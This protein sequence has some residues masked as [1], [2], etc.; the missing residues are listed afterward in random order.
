M[1]AQTDPQ[2]QTTEFVRLGAGATTPGARQVA[3]VPGAEVP[4]LTLELPERLRGQAREQVAR[5]QLRDRIVLDPAQVEMRPFHAQ[6]RAEAWTRVLVADADLVTGWRAAA[7]P[8]CQAVLPDYL[9]LPTT[10]ALWTV[11]TTDQEVVARLGPTDGFAAA[12]D[13]AARMIQQALHSTET[14]PPKALLRLGAPIPA[15]EALVLARNIP[16]ITTAQEARALGLADPQVLAHGELQFDLRLDPQAARAR[17][18]QKVLPW[19]WPI[20]IGLVAA[21]LFAATELISISRFTQ[22][23]RQVRSDTLAMV[24]ES[25]VPV[26]PILDIRTQVSR[27]LATRRAQTASWG[28]RVA[29]LD[30]LGQAAG[31]I[32]AHSAAPELISYSPAEGLVLVLRVANFAAAEDL[33]QAL[34]AEGLGV[35]QSDARV[36]DSQQGVRVELRL[37]ALPRSEAGQ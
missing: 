5:R 15:I 35:E 11:T 1:T 30:L 19:R 28:G 4:V 12:P 13:V 37:T 24:R 10:E 18:R 6:G 26:G 7:G 32:M 8:A 21:G 33:L 17:V 29:P 23:E 20:L 34:Q 36:S 14:P 9:A 16:V 31:G 3:L 22:E 27:A 25:F 2:A